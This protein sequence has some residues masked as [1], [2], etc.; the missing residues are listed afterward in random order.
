MRNSIP[1][2]QIFPTKI[3]A[4]FTNTFKISGLLFLYILLADSTLMAKNNSLRTISFDRSWL[5]TKDS[6]FDAE[7]VGFD[8]S[9]WRK[10]D[11]PHDWSIEDLPN[12]TTEK[13]VG[14]FSKS[15]IGRASIGWT[16]GG[17]G[18]YRKKFVIEKTQES[19]LVSIHFD[20]IY[21]SLPGKS[22]LWLYSFLL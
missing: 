12:Q 4:N 8:D 5:F 20:G 18:W 2:L 1:Q 16:V 14:P 21:M 10:V 13:V 22:S 15:S 7:K 9:K 11:L 3:I 19:K 17:T 6:L